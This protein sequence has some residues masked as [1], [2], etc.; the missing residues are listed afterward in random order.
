VAEVTHTEVASVSY[1]TFEAPAKKDKI[2]APIQHSL[3]VLLHRGSLIDREFASSQ[4]AEC[5]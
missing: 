5:R 2:R 1:P 3:D 4:V